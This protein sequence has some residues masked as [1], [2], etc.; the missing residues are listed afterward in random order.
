MKYFLIISHLTNTFILS[1]ESVEFWMRVFFVCIYF[2]LLLIVDCFLSLLVKTFR[3]KYVLKL[4]YF[5]LLML[6]N[7]KCK[8]SPVKKIVGLPETSGYIFKK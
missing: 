4:E 8:L 6:Q 5:L 7:V 1:T 2:L 3:I